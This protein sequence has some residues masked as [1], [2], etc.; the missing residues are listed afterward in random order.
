MHK[1]LKENGI[2]YTKI[3]DNNILNIPK[4]LQVTYISPGGTV[5]LGDPTEEC[6]IH[7][8]IAKIINKKADKKFMNAA[9][10]LII[11][12]YVMFADI[13]SENESIACVSYREEHTTKR[14]H[15]TLKYLKKYYGYELIND[16]VSDY[17]IKQIVG[18]EMPGEEV[19][20]A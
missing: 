17:D 15:E 6:S 18:M 4:N 19:A 12:G 7:E 9:Q 8:K 10:N 5:I 20:I 13:S 2:Q 3:N 16:A 1:I 14:Q 11:E